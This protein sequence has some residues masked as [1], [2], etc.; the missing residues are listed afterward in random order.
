MLEHVLGFAEHEH[1]A[2]NFDNFEHMLEHRNPE[3]EHEHRALIEHFIFKKICNLSNQLS[4][5][6]KYLMVEDL[7]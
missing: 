2:P 4:N 7:E 1:W 6:H 3:H 5:D